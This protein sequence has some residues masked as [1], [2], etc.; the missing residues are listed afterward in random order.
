MQN[1][2]PRMGDN[3]E[4]IKHTLLI[5]CTLNISVYQENY[6]YEREENVCKC[7][8][9]PESQGTLNVYKMSESWRAQH[10]PVVDIGGNTGPYGIYVN[11]SPCDRHLC[12]EFD[13]SNSKHF[14]KYKIYKSTPSE[15]LQ[16]QILNCL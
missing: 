4:N 15:I 8:S 9:P 7:V 14:W 13:T 1:T 5:F 12:K 6:A 10:P 11:V 3:I 2:I 16:L